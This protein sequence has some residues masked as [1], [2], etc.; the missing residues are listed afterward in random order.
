MVPH[1]AKPLYIGISDN[2]S[3]RVRQHYDALTELWD[4]DGPISKY[5][6]GHPNAS[7]EE[8]LD[9]LGLEHSFAISARIKRHSS[10]RLGSVH[11]SSRKPR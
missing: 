7:V 4:L 10:K 3:T 5:L 11:M 2:L 1:F 6:D 9:Q 8:V